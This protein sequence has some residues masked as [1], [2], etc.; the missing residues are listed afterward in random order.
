MDIKEFEKVVLETIESIPEKFQ[1]KLKNISV[2][3]E[4][5]DEDSVFEKEHGA[6]LLGLYQGLPL[7]MRAGKRR[8]I[9]DKITIYK[10]PLEKISRNDTELKKNIRRVVL[11]EIGHFFGLD[12]DRLNDLGY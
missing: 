9:P 4:E 7:T 11:H 3:I 5:N 8:L 1:K 10:E 6:T 12:E 2:V